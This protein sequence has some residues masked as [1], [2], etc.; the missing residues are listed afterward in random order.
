VYTVGKMEILTVVNSLRTSETVSGYT[1]G[2]MVASIEVNG[3][4]I[5]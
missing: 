5:E 2:E 4:A 1:N 3:V